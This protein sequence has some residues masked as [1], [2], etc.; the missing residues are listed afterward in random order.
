M[1]SSITL[2]DAL[3]SI[4]MPSGKTKAVVEAWENEV[5]DLASKSDLGQTER[6]L[7]ASISE[8]GAEL[9]VVIREQGVELR[10]SVKEQGLEL[11]SSI[12]ALEAQGKIVHWQFGIIFICIS[13][14]SIKLGYDFLNR[15]LLGE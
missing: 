14:P 11:R 9:R 7:K 2:Y 6:H 8:L 3:T 10:S 13:V 1:K 4:S 12:T 5:K 15:A